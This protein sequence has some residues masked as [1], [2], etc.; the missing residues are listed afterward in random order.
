MANTFLQ[1]DADKLLIQ[2]HRRCCIC[3]RF[4]GSKME[5][6]HMLPKEQG[7]DNTI[8]NAIALCF[9]CHAEVHAYNDKHPRAENSGRLN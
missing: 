3:H 4:C 1:K 2:C 5:L 7:G 6:D 9:E 8:E